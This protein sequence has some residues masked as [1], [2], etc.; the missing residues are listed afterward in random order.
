MESYTNQAD[1]LHPQANEIKH[2]PSH[3]SC[4]ETMMEQQQL[5]SQAREMESVARD[6][7]KQMKEIAAS[8]LTIPSSTLLRKVIIS[9]KNGKV[10][11][12]INQLSKVVNLLMGNLSHILFRP[13]SDTKEDVILLFWSTNMDD[14]ECEIQKKFEII[15][16]KIAVDHFQLRC[17]VENIP[18]PRRQFLYLLNNY[19]CLKAQSD[20][21]YH[22]PPD[23]KEQLNNFLQLLKNP[24]RK[25]KLASTP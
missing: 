13:K 19:V 24:G 8:G 17:V 14:S 5:L 16:Q 25:Q 2:P 15:K 22:L 9:V 23:N 21:V 1:E 12:C 18:S 7:R 3:T 6:I 20:E 10:M 11:F 4:Y